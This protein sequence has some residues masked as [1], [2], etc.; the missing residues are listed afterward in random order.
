MNMEFNSED[1]NQRFGGIARLYG[2]QG[3]KNLLN[4]RVMVVGLGGVGSWAAESLARSGVGA[5]TLVDLDDICITNTNRQLP[6]MSG[7]YGKLKI[8]V[9]KERILAINPQC[10]VH[11]IEDFFTESSSEAILDNRFDYVID[12]IDSLKNKCLLASV[13]LEKNIPIIATGGTA[14]KTNP[15]LITISDLGESINDSLM[16]RMRKKLR[17]EFNFPNA[18][19]FTQKKKQNFNIMC[20]YSPEDSVYPTS[21]GGTCNIPDPESNL[22]LDCESGMGSVTHMTAMFGFM[23]AGHVINTI[24]K[25]SI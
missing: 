24:A 13:C 18:A 2:V 17:Q 12:A 25:K 8:Q 21:D 4:A 11:A 19:K 3:L 20:V 5:I 16:F 1:F 14:G 6:A 7:H 22:K 10:Q 9:I 15:A 23:A